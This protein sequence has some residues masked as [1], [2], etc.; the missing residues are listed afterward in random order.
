MITGYGLTKFLLGSVVLCLVLL[1][2][3]VAP[4]YWPIFA[5]VIIAHL[6]DYQVLKKQY[7]KERK[8]DLNL[9][10]GDTD[11]GGLNADIE[12]QKVPNF[13]LITDPYR[14]PFTNKQFEHTLCSHTIEHVDDPERFYEELRRVSENVTLIVPPLW[15][16]GTAFDVLEHK[17]QY[18]TFHP[19]HVNHLPQRIK[20]APWWWVRK[21]L[22]VN[23]GP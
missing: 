12:Q 18:L 9:S 20:L 15:D 5:F 16:I 14:L 4:A 11:G 3:S 22:G 10:C 23:A 17:W 1:L 13:V 19:K 2:L 7:L 8:W 6:L 21:Q